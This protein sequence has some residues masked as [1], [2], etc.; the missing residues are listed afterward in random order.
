MKWN[1]VLLTTKIASTQQM[2]FKVCFYMLRGV[3]LICGSCILYCNGMTKLEP[4]T[5]MLRKSLFIVT[6]HLAF[7]FNFVVTALC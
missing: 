6:I 1:Q 4:N 2:I 3:V 7:A 5:C